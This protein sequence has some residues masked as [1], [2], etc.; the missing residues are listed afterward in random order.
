M[1]SYTI[2]MY[3]ITCNLAVYIKRLGRALDA[4]EMH[5]FVTD[6]IT[7]QYPNM[8]MREVPE[9]REAVLREINKANINRPIYA[10]FSYRTVF[11]R[12][13]QTKPIDHDE[14]FV[15][16]DGNHQRVYGTDFGYDF[17]NKY[18]RGSWGGDGDAA[19]NDEGTV[20]F[21]EE[22]LIDAFS[23]KGNMWKAPKT[24]RNY[25][26]SKGDFMGGFTRIP[27]GARINNRLF[28]SLPFE[29]IKN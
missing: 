24:W 16:K 7:K 18:A 1:P 17:F 28:E 29:M 23:Y 14:Y 9:V 11:T 6:E 4:R 5:H 15:D 19:D 20:D 10:D 3:T 25:R 27:A 12:E 22:E 8:L 21:D 13:G 26:E 2:N